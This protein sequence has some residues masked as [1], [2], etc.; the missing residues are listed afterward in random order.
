MIT[1]PETSLQN[2][3]PN[4]KRTIITTGITEWIERQIGLKAKVSC[5]KQPRQTASIGILTLNRSVL[6]RL[7]LDLKYN[8]LEL[9]DPTEALQRKKIKE[10]VVVS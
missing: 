8:L 1:Y 7:H 6:V 5:Q 2:I 4:N 9:S 3:K 10:R